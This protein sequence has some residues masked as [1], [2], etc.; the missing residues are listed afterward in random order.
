M[1]LNEQILKRMKLF[2]LTVPYSIQ[3]IGVDQ[4]GV[5]EED[6]QVAVTNGQVT[7][8]VTLESSIPTLNEL[9]AKA[10]LGLECGSLM[11]SHSFNK[12]ATNEEIKTFL[13]VTAPLVNSFA[14]GLMKKY[15]PEKDFAKE[16]REWKFFLES[17]L[18]MH[19]PDH[20]TLMSIVNLYITL[21]SN[22]IIVQGVPDKIA[23]FKEPI[24]ILMT[25]TNE[26]PSQELLCR[27]ANLIIGQVLHVM[28]TEKDD[29]R[30]IFHLIRLEEKYSA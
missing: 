12:G 3:M 11:C 2:G 17:L 9:V 6:E 21:A 4:D 20:E 5:P 23:Q 16:V 29:G 22:N 8:A 26:E 14:F 10:K 30:E 19:D 13:Y 7:F 24:D 15:L 1:T 25:L 27:A 18:S 28:I